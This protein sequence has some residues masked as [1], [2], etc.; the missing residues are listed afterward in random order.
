ME[1]VA[2]KDGDL[3]L[4]FPSFLVHL[5]VKRKSLICFLSTK[6]TRILEYLCLLRGSDKH[7]RHRSPRPKNTARKK[8]KGI[9]QPKDSGL[10]VRILL[11]SCPAC[12]RQL[13]VYICLRMARI[14]VGSVFIF[15]GPP[16][17]S[18]TSTY[19]RSPLIRRVDLGPKNVSRS[20]L[21]CRRRRY[22]TRN[23]YFLL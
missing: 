19:I 22:C 7:R 12:A 5:L 3:L 6:I 18:A 14:H 21:S 20:C 13:Y 10:R 17:L 8:K 16:S 9:K 11:A 1:S 15:P 23:Q 2:G 4:V